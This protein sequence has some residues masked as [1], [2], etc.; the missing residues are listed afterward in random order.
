MG[1]NLWCLGLLP[2]FSQGLSGFVLTFSLSAILPLEWW[3]M[4]KPLNCL[5]SN[6]GN[7]L[8][9]SYTVPLSGNIPCSAM[10]HETTLQVKSTVR[11]RQHISQTIQNIQWLFRSLLVKAAEEYFGKSVSLGSNTHHSLWPATDQPCG[12]GNA[13]WQ[14]VSLPTCQGLILPICKWESWVKSRA[15]ISM[16]CGE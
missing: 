11:G 15:F 3:C 14:N 4:Y 10:W 13:I 2:I 7:G 6:C 5:F 1:W 12:L 16:A 8:E 9:L